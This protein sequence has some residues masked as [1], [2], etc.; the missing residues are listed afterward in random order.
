MAVYRGG[1][2]DRFFFLV[3]CLVTN[4]PSKMPSLGNS[5]EVKWLGLHAFT[6]KSAGSITG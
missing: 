2:V 4:C 5:L 6:A 1:I 3:C